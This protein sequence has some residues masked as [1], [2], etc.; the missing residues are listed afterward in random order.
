MCSARTATLVERRCVGLCGCGWAAARCARW[1]PCHPRATEHGTTSTRILRAIDDRV[2]AAARKRCARSGMVCKV[3]AARRAVPV[4]AAIGQPSYRAGAGDRNRSRAMGSAP[5]AA[6]AIKPSRNFTTEIG[7]CTTEI[8]HGTLVI[9]QA[10]SLAPQTRSLRKDL[11]EQDRQFDM[12]ATLAR[13]GT[14]RPGDDDDG[15]DRAVIR[16]ES[17]LFGEMARQPLADPDPHAAFSEARDRAAR[18]PHSGVRVTRSGRG[19]G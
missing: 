10:S 19:P 16:I 4:R 1:A 8:G 18:A 6:A 15:S 11:R 9:D 2:A 3:R 12:K 13:R 14:A 7:S 5:L 17:R